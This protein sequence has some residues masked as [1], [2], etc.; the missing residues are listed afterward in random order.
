MLE[1][2]SY[3]W[4]EI[5][6]GE[7]LNA[8]TYRNFNSAHILSLRDP[9]IFFLDTFD[10]PINLGI[11]TA[12]RGE[13]ILEAARRLTCKAALEGYHPFAG[14]LSSIEVHPENNVIKAVTKDG[15]VV[16]I[17]YNKLRIFDPSDVRGLPFESE[18]NVKDYRV[19]DIYDVRSG[20]MHKFDHIEDKNS[21]FV[22]RIH[23]FLSERIDGNKKYKD[24]VSESR[25]TKEQLY[26]PNYSDSV[27]RLKTISMMKAS[28]I[29][30]TLNGA[31]TPLSIRL[32]LYQRVVIPNKEFTFEEKGNIIVDNR[33]TEQVVNE[34]L[35][36]CRYNPDSGPTT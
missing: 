5:V 18:V 14:K 7:N 11:L 36:S 31:S 15:S 13:L 30:G 1:S 21:Q 3:E 10:S 2:H 29:K 20:T 35:S 17:K 9:S 16:Y 8:I 25:M 26:D 12:T 22:N 33:S 23:F 24:L 19:L 32:E 27:S 28:G 6:I 4:D 34:Q